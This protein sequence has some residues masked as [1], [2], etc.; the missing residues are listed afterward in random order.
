MPRTQVLLLTGLGLMTILSWALESTLIAQEESEFLPQEIA[1]KKRRESFLALTGFW[2]DKLR[3]GS[4]S[5][6]EAAREIKSHCETHYPRYLEHLNCAEM[7]ATVEE[8]V[9]RNLIRSFREERVNHP[10]PD[11]DGVLER[12]DQE[13]SGWR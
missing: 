2:M 3:G 6:R 10:S 8:R 11:L 1:W 7:G 5:L 13:L 12:L 9:A 4:V